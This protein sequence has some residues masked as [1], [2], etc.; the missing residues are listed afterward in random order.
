MRRGRT[1]IAQPA[2]RRA[3]WPRCPGRP[4]SRASWRSRS[5]RGALRAPGGRL[6]GA[7]RASATTARRSTLT[8]ALAH[9]HEGETRRRRGRLAHAT[10]STAAS[11]TVE[12]V[13]SREPS[14]DAA[15]LRATCSRSSTSGLRGAAWLLDRHGAEACST[16]STATRA[17]ALREVPGHRRAADRRRRCARGR[18]SGARARCGCSSTSHGV[19]AAAAARIDRALGPDAIEHAAGRPVR[20]DRGRRDRLRDRRR[21]RPRA[22]HAARRARAASTPGCS[23]RCA[24]GRGRRPLPPAA[25]RARASARGGCSGADADDRI[26]ELAALGRA[27]RRTARRVSDPAMDAIER[28][29]ARSVRE[30]A[31]VAAGAAPARARQPSARRA[32]TSS[33]PT[34]SGRPSTT[35]ARAPA[36]DPH[37]RAGHRQDGDDARARRPAARPEARPCGCA[38]RPARRRGGSAEAHGRG[39]DD[40]PPAAR[41]GR[42]GEGFARGPDDP[43][44]GRDVLVVDEASMLSRPPRRRAARRRR[45]AHARAARRRRRPARRRSAPGRVLEDL[46]ESGAVP[47]VRLTEIF[48]QAARSLIVRAAHAINARRAAADRRRRGRHPRLL[49]PRARRAAPAIFEEVVSL[50]VRR[51]PG[52]LR[53]RPRARVLVLSPM[54]RA[55]SASTRFNAELRARLNPDGAPIPGTAVP[56]RRPRR[57][58]AATTTSTSS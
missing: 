29:L 36:V 45:P 7:R 3:R 24:P 9:V 26:D 2:S 32:A 43:I 5:T 4:R 23:T 21:A 15:L 6:R 49:L 27:R 13:R 41:V 14:S 38:R 50:A 20:D 11:S 58:D 31:D 54:H 10:P 35:G 55:R 19:P 46:I 48:R 12:R 51:L 44:P 17:R 37:R 33:R 16:T 18:S 30:L 47:T 28:R 42:P 56:R 8:G 40:D 52:A 57:P 1:G 22:R 34:P 53:A 39:G 25:R